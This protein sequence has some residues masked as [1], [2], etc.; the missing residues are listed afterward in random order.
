VNDYLKVKHAKDIIG[1][2]RSNL[3]RF[4]IEARKQ[5]L[6]AKKNKLE[7]LVKKT[8]ETKQEILQQK[9]KQSYLKLIS[10]DVQKG[11]KDIMQENHEK[12]VKTKLMGKHWLTCMT[13]MNMAR[14]IFECLQRGR[15]RE[16]I[17][18]ERVV[19]ATMIAVKYRSS[20]RFRG[21][22]VRYRTTL[23]IRS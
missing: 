9:R 15:E 4:S 12:R 3:D 11:L 1:L 20:Q 17:R 19:A 18:L 10:K 2:N 16:R 5:S 13:M 22:D 8:L 6:E 14:H 21:P 7:S 23:D